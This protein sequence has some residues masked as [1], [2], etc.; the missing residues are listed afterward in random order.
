M[1]GIFSKIKQ[2]ST[3]ITIILCG[4]V[5]FLWRSS[6]NALAREKIQHA[7]TKNLLVSVQADNKKLNIYNFEKDEKIKQI[8]DLFVIKSNT[9]PS[10]KCG[11]EIIPDELLRFFKANIEKE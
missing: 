5:F 8:E 3:W 4:I 1:I 11:D 9:L 2:Y 10:N 6:S 7:V